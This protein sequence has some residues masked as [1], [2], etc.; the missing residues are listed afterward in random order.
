MSFN[1]TT[2][3]NVAGRKIQNWATITGTLFLWGADD[4]ALPA[5]QNVDFHYWPFIADTENLSTE[6]IML[7]PFNH[8][9]M[10]DSLDTLS[11]TVVNKQVGDQLSNIV[12][13]YREW[14]S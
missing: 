9:L 2:D 14:I 11:I 1:L 8:L 3:A 13:L 5:S 12:T 4:T 7:I 10:F 6:S